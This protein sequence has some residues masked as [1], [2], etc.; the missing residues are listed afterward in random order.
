MKTLLK[1]S[2]AFLLVVAVITA[3]V[4]LIVGLFQ[5]TFDASLWNA[6]NSAPFLVPT[7]FG[8]MYAG[9]AIAFTILDENTKNRK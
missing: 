3:P 1:A 4:Y 7:V 5:G 2:A 6:P 9:L 8:A